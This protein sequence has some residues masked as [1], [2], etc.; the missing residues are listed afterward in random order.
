MHF[1][2]KMAE[3]ITKKIFREKKTTNKVPLIILEI[4]VLKE[5]RQLVT[6]PTNKQGPCMYLA[7]KNLQITSKKFV[8]KLKGNYK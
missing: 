5:R 1:Q 3:I 4:S 8:R 2:V 6:H 7:F